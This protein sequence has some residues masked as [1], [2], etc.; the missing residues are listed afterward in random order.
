M[1]YQLT[2]NIRAQ[3][4]NGYESCTV[5]F[6]QVQQRET[7]GVMNAQPFEAKSE[8]AVSI[9]CHEHTAKVRVVGNGNSYADNNDNGGS[10][11]SIIVILFVAFLFVP[12]VLGF[13]R[14]YRNK[15]LR[16]NGQPG[17]AIEMIDHDL[18][19]G[20]EGDEEDTEDAPFLS[21]GD[22]EAPSPCCREKQA[23]VEEPL[24][25]ITSLIGR[26]DALRKKAGKLPPEQTS[27]RDDLYLQSKECYNACLLRDMS[28]VLAHYGN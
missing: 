5:L 22:A 26:G 17:G 1:V 4:T 23:R 10:W 28:C 15:M 16:M 7:E 3:E 18:E 13:Y 14:Y 2:M 11:G 24:E 12:C 6:S 8:K 25:D 21:G 19:H 20:D 27:E 9:P